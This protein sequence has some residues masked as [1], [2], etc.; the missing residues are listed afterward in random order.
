MIA[1]IGTCHAGTAVHIP[2]NTAAGLPFAPGVF[3]IICMSAALCALPAAKKIQPTQA[4]AGARVRLFSFFSLLACPA[5]PPPSP[6]PSC[7][8][9]LLLTATT[10]GTGAAALESGEPGAGGICASVRH[11]PQL[12]HFFVVVAVVVVV[13]LLLLLLLLLSSLGKGAPDVCSCPRCGR[14]FSVQRVP[15]P[16]APQR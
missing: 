5:P 8:F 4:C 12:Q 1:S 9:L 13:L 14:C 15:L 2:I 11:A 3:S 6:H 7:R 10:L 16:S